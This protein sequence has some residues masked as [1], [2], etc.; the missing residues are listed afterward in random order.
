MSKIIRV[1]Y[2]IA[3]RENAEQ[4]AGH[5]Q[6]DI[7]PLFAVMKGNLGAKVLRRE[8]EDG[9]EF[10][11]MTTWESL[12]AIKEFAGDDLEKAV[13]AETARPFFLRYDE[14]VAHFRVACEMGA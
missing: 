2:G 11:V 3:R 7:F 12:E 8:V 4:Y 9:V 1:W 6:N 5:V 10:L 14:R 13:V